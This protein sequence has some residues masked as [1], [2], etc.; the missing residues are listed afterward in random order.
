MTE[1]DVQSRRQRT[2][3]ELDVLDR[4]LWNVRQRTRDRLVGKAHVRAPAWVADREDPTVLLARHGH[5]HRPREVPE[6]AAV[7]HEVR[8]STGPKLQIRSKVAGPHAGRVDDG[9]A[10]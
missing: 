4:R 10:P 2:E 5:V 6:A 8:A 3:Q 7:E 1:R 9:H